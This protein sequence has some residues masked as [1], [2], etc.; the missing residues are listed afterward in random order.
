[1][2]LGDIRDSIHSCARRAP[3]AND[4]TRGQTSVWPCGLMTAKHRTPQFPTD[5]V[6]NYS[7]GPPCQAAQRV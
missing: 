7:S 3:S 2:T 6:M 4:A 5:L 1:M